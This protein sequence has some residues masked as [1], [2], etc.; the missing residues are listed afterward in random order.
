MKRR[1]V[2]V[3]G[4]AYEYGHEPQKEALHII[5]DI[6]PFKS[7]DGAFISGR[8]QW[9]E[10]LK[11]TDS[12]EMSHSDVKAAQQQWGKRKEA[13]QDRLKGSAECIAD[14]Q[15]YLPKGEVRPYVPSQ[16]NVEMANR[17]HG[18]PMPERKEMI[19]LTLDIA[20]RM[21]RGR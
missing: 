15:K 11:A 12:I 10:H 7:P 5:P 20:R 16:L 3:D 14:A 17:L 19:K 8:R 13:Y 21:N 18:R 9:R 4:E 6:E 2:Y 1:W